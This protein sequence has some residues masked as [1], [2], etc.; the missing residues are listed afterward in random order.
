MKTDNIVSYL[1]ENEERLVEELR[2]LL[3]QPSVSAQNIGVKECAELLRELMQKAGIKAKVVPLK[4]GHPLVLG[5]VASKVSKRTLLIYSHYDVQPTDPLEEWKYD[6]F[7]AEMKNGVIYARGSSDA[8]GNLMTAIKAVEYYLDRFGDVPVNLKFIFEGEEEIESPRLPKFIKDNKAEL[9]ADAVVCLDGGMDRSGR[10]AINLGVKGML[11]LELWCRGSKADLHSAYAPIVPNP[12][13]R[14]VHVLQTLRKPSGEIAIEGWCEDAL[15]PTPEEM[16]IL[17]EIPFNEEELKEQFGIT[18][19]LQNLRGLEA[20][21]ALIFHPT[22][23]ICGVKAGY[24][25]PGLKTVLP[26]EAMAKID[27]RLVPNQ[28]PDVLLKRLKEHLVDKGFGDI[29]VRV[30]GS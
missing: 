8:K 14:L 7:A 18:S 21:K 3:R 1:E 29:E 26:S 19:F 15:P 20:L 30:I 23:T 13:W 4:G 17:R 11:Y 16:E 25:G 10:P 27:F 2:V 22:C 24:S 5:E 12:L 28:N 6:P 9:N